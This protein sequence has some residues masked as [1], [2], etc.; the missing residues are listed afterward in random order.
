MPHVLAVNDI[1]V[2]KV[3][4]YDTGNAQVGIN[5]I[6]YQVSSV[7]GASAINDGTWAVYFDGIM[8]PVYKAWI[9]NNCSYRGVLV[10]VVAPTV[11]AAQI[12]SANTGA[13]TGGANSLPDQV[14]GLIAFK[15]PLAGRGYRGRIYPPFPST[16]WSN[17]AGQMN[18]AG[19][20]VLGN[21]ETA[22]P[23]S[24]TLTAGAT[25]ATLVQVIYHR[26]TK[27]ATQVLG[28]L[29]IEMFATQR[30]RGQEGRTNLIPF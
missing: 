13:G 16:A 30:R 24:H 19:F 4:C 6:W 27:T 10:Q 25:S 29:P 7:T 20:L 11:Y 18:N 21:I 12:S 15:T 9:N 3:I 8:A 26:K 28:Q 14:S 23:L 2:S 17:A 1:L 5:N 22:I